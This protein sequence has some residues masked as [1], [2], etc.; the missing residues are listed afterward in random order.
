MRALAVIATSL[1]LAACGSSGGRHDPT[2]GDLAV[3]ERATENVGL[4]CDGR[5]IGALVKVLASADLDAPVRLSDAGGQGRQTTLRRVT[6]AIAGVL[7]ACDQRALAV[8]LRTE[9]DR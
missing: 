6:E 2:A 8:R 3:V 5:D 1:A 4:R 9:L 7:T